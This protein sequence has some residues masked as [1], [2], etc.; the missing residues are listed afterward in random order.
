VPRA[1]HDDTVGSLEAWHYFLGLPA[2]CLK[3]EARLGRLA[4]SR[5]AGKLWTTG[6]SIKR[7]L[8]E[9]RVEPR[10]VARTATMNGN[11]T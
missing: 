3:R 11:G 4:V 10:R 1:V 2:H 9:G 7:W 6:V 5:R 8:E